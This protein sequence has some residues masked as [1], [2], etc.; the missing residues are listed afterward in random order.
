M[1][2]LA[3]KQELESAKKAEAER[4]ANR[5]RR[6]LNFL[7]SQ[8]E[9][10]S[11]FIGR[12]IK[13]AGRDAA[14]DTTVDATEETVR[15]GKAQ[16]HTVDLPPSVADAKAKVT[17]FE[18]L[19]F[20]AE[21]ETSLR[22]AAMANAQIA[23]QEA[24]DRARA[25]NPD[26]PMAAFD[27]GEMNFQNPTSLGDIDISQ[28]EM[29]TTKLKEYQLK[30]LNWLVNLYEQGINGILADEMGLG[31]T[32][33]SISVMAYLAEFHNI[34]GP[35]LVIA[36]SSTLHNWQQEITKFVPD[37]KVLPYWGSAKDRKILR[38]FWDRKHIT[39]TRESEFH[40][41]VTS[42]QLVVLDAQYSRR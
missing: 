40:V 10:Y 23:V 13:T 33:Q 7:I 31:K 3:E 27:E 15:P 5:Q 29:L 18:D 35:F 25:F 26:Q 20:D 1:R 21:D 36:P 30:G 38:K 11:H 17:N 16:D 39:Y 41:L 24:Q 12:K 6:K 42:Y 2:R 14:G 34:W 22:Q 9:L 8:T 19:D 28:P 4:E 37:I 32:I